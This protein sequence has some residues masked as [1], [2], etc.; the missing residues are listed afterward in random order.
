[1]SLFRQQEMED[2]KRWKTI[3]MGR[4]PREIFSGELKM[5]GCEQL[6]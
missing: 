4:V 3:E 6:C 2:S 1:M 5:G